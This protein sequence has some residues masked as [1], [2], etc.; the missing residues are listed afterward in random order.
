MHTRRDF[1]RHSCAA[2]ATAALPLAVSNRAFAA[3]ERDSYAP[4]DFRYRIT[5]REIA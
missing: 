5:A 2:S 1:L 3:E 4:D